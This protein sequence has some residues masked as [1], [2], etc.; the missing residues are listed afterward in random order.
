MP[1]QSVVALPGVGGYGVTVMLVLFGVLLT[2]WVPFVGIAPL[3]L[4]AWLAWRTRRRFQARAAHDELLS[5]L[6]DVPDRV[7]LEE[8]RTSLS[9]SPFTAADWRARHEQ[10]YARILAA[11]I[12]EGIDDNERSWLA[13]VAAA[14]QVPDTKPLD[15]EGLR[16]ALWGLMADG[17]VTVEEERLAERLTRDAGVAPEDLAEEFAVP[18]QF[19]R[20]PLADQPRLPHRGISLSTGRPSGATLVA[21]PES[22]RPVLTPEERRQAKQWL[23]NWAIAGPALEH[24]RWE[25]LTRMTPEEYQTATRRVWELWQPQWP[26]DDGESLLLQ[27]RVFALARHRR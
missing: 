27:Q 16:V 26:T 9:T 2:P 13:G 23:D 22:P 18:H 20:H 15:V 21:M 1:A 3:A 10:V 4:A 5:K 24:E 7:L 11:V 6:T 25:R 14:L 17:I 12:E 8:V 19:Q